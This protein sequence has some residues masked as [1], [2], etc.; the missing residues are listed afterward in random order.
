MTR[1]S[2]KE[3]RGAP[4]TATAHDGRPI[5]RNDCRTLAWAVRNPGFSLVTGDTGRLHGPR[6]RPL[7]V[8]TNPRLAR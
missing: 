4:I 2:L 7:E 3:F 5:S 8:A 1:M 6:S